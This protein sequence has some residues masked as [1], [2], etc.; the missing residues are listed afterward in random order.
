MPPPCGDGGWRQPLSRG[1]SRGRPPPRRRRRSRAYSA[2][3]PSAGSAIPCTTQSDGTRVCQGDFSSSGGADTRLKSFDGTPLAL[4]VILPPAPASGTDGELPAGGAE[5][6]LGR[7]RPG[8]PSDTQYGGPT[9]MPWAKDGY[10]VLQLTARGFGRLLRQR[11]LAARRPHRL[12]RT[13]TSASTTTATRCRDVQNAIGLLVDEGIANPAPDRRDRRVLRRRRV[14]GAGHAARPRDERRRLGEPVAQPGRHA[15]AHRRRRAGHPVER[16]RLLARSPTGARSTT[17]WPRPPPTSRRSGS[18]SSRSSPGLYAL[19]SLSGFYA[20]AGTNSQADLTTWFARAQR[21]RALRRQCRGR[22][23]RRPDRPVPL[24][25]LP[26]RRSLRRTPEAPAPL[27]IANGFTDDL[28]PVDE[29]LRYYNLERAMY[30]SDPDRPVRL[31]RRPPAR[32]EQGGRRS[33]ALR[34]DPGVPRPLRSRAPAPRPP[35]RRHRAHPDLPEDAPRRAG[36][37]P[38]PPGP[39]CT[40]ARST[41]PRRRPRRSPRARAARPSPRRSIRSP[42]PGP[43]P[44]R[45]PPIRAPA[46]PPIGCRRPPDRA[47]PCS[48]RRR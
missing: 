32:P 38:R 30:P 21:R 36:R 6:R 12:R 28:F 7:A 10:A 9:A 42:G 15:A 48:A 13:A 23:D 45:P 46:S 27:L 1:E 31:R 26:A 37:S 44:P 14:A 24:V 22:G 39:A 18:R 4:Y 41:S 25:L 35:A 34:S 33:A 20:P 19:G 3:T 43:A 11:G 8:G 40:P 17:R 47:T 5:P 29:A 16:P 2:A